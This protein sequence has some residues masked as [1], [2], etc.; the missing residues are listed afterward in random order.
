MKE[1][2][3]N[4]EWQR[5][6]AS[7]T[8]F[9][10]FCLPL[11]SP[12]SLP[13]L[14]SPL[15]QSHITPF[16]ILSLQNPFILF[17]FPPCLS[18]STIHLSICLLLSIPSPSLIVFSPPS[19]F[20][21]PLFILSPLH[22]SSF[23]LPILSPLHLSSFTI[24]HSV[25]HPSV[26]LHHPS[27]CLLSIVLPSSSLILSPLHRSSFTLSHSVSPPSFFLHPPSFCLPSIVLPS[28]SLIL[29]PLHR[30]S[31]TIPHSVSPPSFSLTS[32][33]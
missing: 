28:P 3:H 22:L 32:P 10:L 18:P 5:Q 27:F 17:L 31:F 1:Q 2:R 8:S 6:N 24:P 14:S 4:K 23:I 7:S 15:I 16:F 19:F 21:R 11:P 33:H 13:F 25:S 12:V 29:S 9:P 26:F 20:L 30:S